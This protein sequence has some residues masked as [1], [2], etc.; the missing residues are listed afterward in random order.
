MASLTN[1]ASVKLRQLFN[2]YYR[3]FTLHKNANL[4]V[5]NAITNWASGTNKMALAHPI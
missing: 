3:T 4:G 2:D 1:C 5:V